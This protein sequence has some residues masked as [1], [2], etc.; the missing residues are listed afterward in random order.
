MT[1][2]THGEP[3]A[4]TS[5]LAFVVHN[6]TALRAGPPPDDGTATVPLTMTSLASTLHDVTVTRN[7]V[8]SIPSVAGAANSRTGN[9]GDD[10]KTSW[11]ALIVVVR[12]VTTGPRTRPRIGHP[13]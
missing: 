13:S 6:S 3:K 11:R 8:Q 5:P 12:A 4:M 2:S 9:D 7:P 1:G 10:D